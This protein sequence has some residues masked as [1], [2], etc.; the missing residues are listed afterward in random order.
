MWSSVLFNSKISLKLLELTRQFH[1]SAGICPG[2]EAAEG[3][4]RPIAWYSSCHFASP[5]YKSESSSWQPLWT[6]QWI[7]MAENTCSVFGQERKK[8]SLGH[9][10]GRSE[11]KELAIAGKN[12]K[13]Q[14]VNEY[15]MNG[16]Q[17]RKIKWSKA[18]WP[19]YGVMAK[20]RL[21][22]MRTKFALVY[23]KDRYPQKYMYEEDTD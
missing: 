13:E 12:M 20:A 21:H 5:N 15:M 16:R 6:G 11:V 22:W 7:A 19:A 10:K 3:P 18:R 14:R 17:N 9:F 23:S 1:I 2:R 4:R 8:C